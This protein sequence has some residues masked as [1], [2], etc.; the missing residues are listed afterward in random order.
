[1]K[2]HLTRAQLLREWQLRHLPVAELAGCSVT[3]AGGI[4]A[5][6]LMLARMRDWYSTLLAEGPD[7]LLAP[8]DITSRVSLAAN[9]DGS[10]TMTLPGG[11]VRLLTVDM[12]GWSR[13]AV[14]TYSPLSALARRQ[15]SPLT[16]GCPADPVAVVDGLK[17]TLYAPVSG[18]S[19]RSVTAIV[20]DDDDA[21]HLDSA[22]LATIKPFNLY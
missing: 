11:T 12:E 1:M 9:A 16:R 5:E 22:A 7:E 20:D 14:I 19:L 15:R 6:P 2:L 18:G 4:D 13:P 21:F 3:Q 10:A 17:V 8:V